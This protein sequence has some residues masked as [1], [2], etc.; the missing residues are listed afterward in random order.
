MM[1]ILRVLFST[2]FVIAPEGQR[3]QC[4]CYW[5][6]YSVS[7]RS[8]GIAWLRMCL[9]IGRSEDDAPESPELI[10]E[11]TRPDVE[12]ELHPSIVEVAR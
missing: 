1:A 6:D 11:E 8:E 3:Y 4:S 2:L 5:C 10:P 12:A 7:S 9:H